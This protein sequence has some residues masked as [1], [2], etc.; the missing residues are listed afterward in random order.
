MCCLISLLVGKIFHAKLIEHTT[1]ASLKTN[2]KGE[3]CTRTG[4]LVC[5]VCLALIPLHILLV[6]FFLDLDWILIPLRNVWCHFCL[7]F[8]LVS[9]P[10]LYLFE[11]KLL[12]VWNKC[13]NLSSLLRYNFNK[14][15]VV[16]DCYFQWRNCLK[17]VKIALNLI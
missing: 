3:T 12:K 16:D 13:Y 5:H 11:M 6:S 4:F 8:L 2:N 17:L 14:Q 1:T 15:L 10:W 9:H 7:C